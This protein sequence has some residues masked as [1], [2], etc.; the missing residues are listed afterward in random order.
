[1]SDG[2]RHDTLSDRTVREQ[3][4]HTADV[5]DR[6]RADDAVPGEASPGGAVP[7][8]ANPGAAVSGAAVSGEANPGAAVP[9]RAAPS[10]AERRDEGSPREPQDEYEAELAAERRHLD[11]VREHIERRIVAG[12]EGI[13]LSNDYTE[14]VLNAMR[15]REMDQL[16][17]SRARP[18]FAKIDFRER[19]QPFREEGYI[20]RFGLFDP[21]TLA[22]IVLDWR[23]PMAS[24]YYEHRFRD[25]PVE[26]QRGDRLRF[27]VGKKR[28]FEMERETISRFFDM[29]E[30]TGTNRLLIERLEQRGEQKLRDIVET[31]QAEQ[32]AVL[33]ADPTRALIV[34]GAAGSGKTTIALHRLAFLAYSY[35]D[36]GTFDNFLIIAPNRMFIDYISDVL[37]DLGVDGVVQTTWEEALLKHIPLPKGYAFAEAAARTAQFLEADSPRADD[38]G[39][40]ETM[41]QSSRL[42]GAMAMKRLLDRFVDR[43]IEAAVPETDLALS[44][45]HR[46]SAED[47]R[48][49][50]HVDFRHYPFVQRRKRLIQA[51]TAWKD[52]C[53]KEAARTL[54]SRVKPGQL[55]ATERRVAE[56]KAQY[57]RKLE[58]YVQ[59]I[60]SVEIVSFYLNIMSKP[61]HIAS[62]VKD[63]GAAFADC[64][65]E[66]IAARFAA[67]REA[68]SRELEWEDIAPLF[69][70]AYRFY[71]L[72][73]A[74]A[75]SH[76][77]VDEAQ[78]FSP[79]HLHALGALSASG[80][81]TILGDLAQSIYPYRGLTDWD[82]LKDGVLPA[83]VT[84]ERLKKSYRST[85]EIMTAANRV[86]AHWNHPAIA[87]AEPVLRHGEPPALRRFADEAEGLRALAETIARLRTQGMPNI[88]VID[89]TSVRCRAVHERLAALGIA[90][91]RL[92]VD[93]STKYDAGVSVLPAYLS[94]GMEFDAVLLVNP[95]A[96]AYPADRPEHVK[97]LYVAFTRALH[98]LEV[99]CWDPPSAIVAD[100]FDAE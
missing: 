54:E 52:D 30:E 64:D 95:S 92:V 12:L 21:A 37:P 39:E 94:K 27:D 28:Q 38:A 62:L 44:K 69:Y 56:V 87:Q 36:R 75:F 82:A 83:P 68:K 70:L 32:N 40:R 63:A 45:A 73:K 31:I 5:G 66:R 71:G 81:M 76:I 22:P 89:K 72:G 58:E 53:L 77:I 98:R 91:A 35:R 47:V 49:K 14:Q 29:S 23:S 67:R 74:R 93:R 41:L 6:R 34:Q 16:R 3:R 17:R 13:K 65:P 90:D 2:N 20:G 24:L 18:Y 80:S 10:D 46:M 11:G 84:L 25:V 100:A 4:K 78:D 19:D 50:F 57:E 8:E 85:V 9:G 86:L 48:R 88:A 60:K 51:L 33:R 15:H 43:R 59:Q 61:S 42:R 97:L 55:T 99:F 1:M 26:V 96:E 7:G 79:F